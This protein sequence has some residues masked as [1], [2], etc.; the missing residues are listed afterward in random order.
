MSHPAAVLAAALGLLTLLE[1]DSLQNRSRLGLQVRLALAGA[2]L[3]LIRPIE[4]VALGLASL[5][6]WIFEGRRPR[7]PAMPVPVPAR[8][9]VPVPRPRPRA[10]RAG[11]LCLWG[12]LAIGALLLAADQGR[13]TGHPLLPP[14]TRYFE[15]HLGGADRNRL[16]FG[17]EVGLDWDGSRPGHSPAEALSNLR[18]NA[19]GL[20]RELLGWPAGSLLLALV[21]LLAGSWNR[22]ERLLVRHGGAVIALYALYWYHGSA[23]GPRFLSALAPGL[24]VFTVRGAVISIRTLASLR[25]D[26]S[27]ARQ[28][29]PVSIGISLAA[30]L[31]LHVP[32]MARLDL[33]GLRGVRGDVR[34]A[35]ESVPAPALVFVDGDR[36][37][38]YAPLYFM[39]A[40]D[41]AGPRVIALGRG[42]VLDSVVARSYPERE[43]TRVRAGR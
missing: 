35:V 37:P 30:A 7:S 39:N 33:R 5:L 19:H 23:Y 24:I 22:G 27:H 12:G 34:R 11:L 15:R 42:A 16:G 25:P 28:L 2:A 3:L 8:V 4:G 21:G 36:W 38:D 32:L 29:V 31:L 13:V 9:P 18:R 40:P 41:F 6:D 17:P 43:V 10:S 1:A 26:P 20:E 14:V